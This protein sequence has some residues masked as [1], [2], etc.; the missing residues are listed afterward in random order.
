MIYSG[1]IPRTHWVRENCIV[2][3]GALVF[4]LVFF[5]AQAV[6]SPDII[7]F[8]LVDAESDTRIIELE[9]YQTLTLPFLPTK[10]SIE[11]EANDET[12]SVEMKIE[13]VHSSTEN[14]SP[15][16]LKGDSNGDFVPV[17][18]LRTPG[19][20]TISAQPF[21]AANANGDAGS[22]AS[23]PLY[24]YKPDFL[25]RNGRDVGDYEPGDGYCSIT[26]P[27]VSIDDF[28]VATATPDVLPEDKL[29]ADALLPAS[30]RS[31]E[32]AIEASRR[33]K[34]QFKVSTD[35]VAPDVL[36]EPAKPNWHDDSYDLVDPSTAHGCTLRAAIEEA[37]AL[38]GSQ[39]ILIDG[40]RG[41]FKLTKGQLTI[42]EGVTVRGHEM[43]LIDADKRSR[44]FYIDGG[45][46]NIIVNLQQLDIARGKVDPSSRGGAIRIVNNAL[47]QMSDSIV[48]ESRANFGGGFYLQSGGDLTMSRSAVRDNIAGTP[49]NG[50]TGGGVTQRGGGIY[51]LEGNVTI[52][53]SAIFDNL[54]V[55]G[56]GLSNKGGTM[57]V[58]NSSVIGNEALAI[59]GGI[60]NHHNGAEKGNLHLVFATIANN[61][62]GTSLAPPADQ[63]GG[64]GLY[65]SGWA[66]MAS[67]ILAD[68]SDGW[69]AGDAH[70]SPDCHSPDIYDFKSYRNNVVGVLNDNCS[71]TD[72]SW[73][74]TAWIDFGTEAAPLNPGLT[75][76]FFQGH[77][78]YHNI[79][80]S[81]VALDN[82]GSSSESAIY[83]CED[84]D[85]RS[86]P[87]PVGAGCD[88]GAVER[89]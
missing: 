20:L 45:G 9:K 2:L 60:E 52:R 42:T 44:V 25:V 41:P 18:E 21:S 27:R 35:T 49:D 57:R 81:S 48:R 71:L 85:M 66:Y 75:S 17:P 4:F 32:K 16:A 67:S 83:P 70:H 76:R 64:G 46:D 37:N 89:Q 40:N 54:A 11:A 55:R 47:V 50:I 10:L 73:G 34:S 13:G 53:D 87:R 72:Y 15:Y 63:R 31:K 65:N 61:Q 7:R 51:N 12:Q 6:A 36:D 62:A 69:S 58:E 1:Y 86:R 28:V 8:W 22:E 88:I 23:L 5:S 78:A 80:A 82:G 68:N 19:W 30:A 38:P 26:A 79:S 74:N 84:H 39:S 59:G 43:P 29:R 56:G 33:E 77:L 3:I 24:L 14:I